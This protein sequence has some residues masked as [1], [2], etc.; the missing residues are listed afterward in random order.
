M[1]QIILIKHQCWVQSFY[2]IKKENVTVVSSDLQKGNSAINN[3]TNHY[4]L[5]ALILLG[6][7][8]LNEKILYCLKMV[9]ENNYPIDNG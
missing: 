6:I 4:T 2:K 3:T 5:I 8:S 9:L 7:D 1:K